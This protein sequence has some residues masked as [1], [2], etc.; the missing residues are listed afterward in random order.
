M[1]KGFR[2][3]H[4]FILN[5]LT[6]S[7]IIAQSEKDPFSYQEGVR[8]F[9]LPDATEETDSLAVLLFQEVLRMPS[10]KVSRETHFDCHEKLGILFLIEGKPKRAIQSLAQAKN[11]FELGGLP[12]TLIFNTLVY[13]GDSYFMLNKGDS[14]IYF[15]Q[16]AENILAQK[17]STNDK[18]RLYNSLG[19]TYYEMGNYVQAITYFSKAKSLVWENTA[20]LPSGDYVRLAVESFQSNEASAYANL[21]NFQKAINLYLELLLFTSKPDAI[22]SKLASLYVERSLP[23]SA[24][25]FLG[26]IQS[27][28]ERE[29]L[30]NR[31]LEADIYL[32]QGK[33]KLAENLLRKL[34]SETSVIQKRNF[35]NSYQLGVSHKLLA[36][37]YLE[38]GVYAPALEAIQQA[39]VRF[40]EG[41]TSTD[42]R[43]NPSPSSNNWGM[44]DLFESL[45]IKAS[46]FLK[47]ANS[48]YSDD[49][50]TL[51]F[52]TYRAAF[53]MIYNMG[54]FYDNEEARIFLGERAQAA[55][56][57]AIVL[58]MKRFKST[59]DSNYAWQ[60]FNWT[61]ESKSTAL[62]LALNEQMTRAESGVSNFQKQEERDLKLKLSKTNRQLLESEDPDVIRN[63]ENDLRDIRLELSRI[64]SVYQQQSDP[65]DSTRVKDRLDYTYIDGVTKHSTTALISFFWEGNL[66]YRFI[67]TDSGIQA[68]QITE[69]DKLSKEMDSLQEFLLSSEG[70]TRTKL[71]YVSAE[72]YRILFSD[73]ESTLRSKS[74]WIVFPDSKLTHQPIEMLIDSN[75]KYL[76]ENHVIS[77]QF[78]AKFLTESAVIDTDL[79]QQ[80]VGFAP[81]NK[82]GFSTGEEAFAVLP[83][84]ETELERVYG[85]KY[86]YNQATKQRFLGVVEN[87]SI[88]HL[89]T[90]AKAEKEDPDRAFI[91]FF[92][93]EEDFRLFYDE[94][95]SLDL[96]KARLVFLSACDTHSGNIL[97][98]E[99]LISLSRAFAYAGCANI[100]GSIWKAEDKVVAYLSHKFYVYLEDGFSM[101]KSLQL[102][103]V[104]L[105][106]DP[107]MAQYNH[108]YFWSSLVFI[109]GISPEINPMPIGIWVLIFLISLSI[110]ISIWL[111]L[112]KLRSKR[113]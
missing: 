103:K 96:Q 102:A 13:L 95:Y 2:I 85:Q 61:E 9:D 27:E 110:L 104:D 64:Y 71:D 57:D 93:E 50:F 113:V 1:K 35:D 52:D 67:I 54:N 56:R 84:A 45:L 41:F 11:F 76:V 70:R 97:N 75:G 38:E 34:I 19:V 49:F 36:K 47:A 69:A 39:I 6:L 17:Q 86:Y 112:H 25:F 82:K 32:S 12:D 94:L 80:S 24:A 78:S 88:I 83:Y 68:T 28:S 98:S 90:H 18:G 31:N 55:Y 79:F 74:A 60:A 72:V 77:Y 5:F 101:A 3:F 87:A 65:E 14:S 111:Y 23:D 21:R 107:T 63:L 4:S 108:P 92:P 30:V 109:G 7:V 59:G 40:S 26:K 44:L 99:G 53:S 91:A 8:L 62:E 33:Y 10:N 43:V 22:Y 37:V 81:F 20:I 46:V 105:L 73:V 16:Q 100:V 29:L 42:Y 48:G 58:S 66:L 51:G 89:A 15:L 106:K